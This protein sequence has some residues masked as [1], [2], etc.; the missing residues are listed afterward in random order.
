MNEYRMYTYLDTGY[1]PG[2]FMSTIP[3]YSLNHN[4][5]IRILS[6]IPNASRQHAGPHIH[7]EIFPELL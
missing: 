5:M 6:I 1:V 2:I 4:R 3:S 7:S